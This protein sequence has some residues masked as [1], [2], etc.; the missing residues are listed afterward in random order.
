MAARIYRTPG[1]RAHPRRGGA[2][3][4]EPLPKAVEQGGG[5]SVV[6]ERAR[7]A[8]GSLALVA[9]GG[10]VFALLWSS[11][12]SVAKILVA[13]APPFTISAL[14]FFVAAAIAAAIARAL[15]QPF[16]RGAD[17]W[18]RILLLG[19]CQN[20]LYLG[21]FFAAMTRIPAALAAIIASAMPLV[22]AALAP[23]VVGERVSRREAAGLVAG[24]AGVAWIMGERLAGGVDLFGVGLA[25]AGVLA[26]SVATL[27][28]KRGAFGSGL[29]MV[30]ACQMLVGGLGCVPL[31]LL[32][33]DVTAINLDGE[34]VAAF[35]YQVLMPGIVATLIWF[36]LVGRLTAAGAS[37]FHFLNPIFGVA[38]A[39]LLL[40]EALTPADAVG[41]VL[42]AAG[43]LIVNTARPA[44]TATPR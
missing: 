12:F 25:V 20:T 17:A 2:A 44:R 3:A 23:A 38:F 6:S 7:P 40:G 30:V 42:V 28:V 21:L 37:A 10:I 1:R 26:L 32:F 5:M 9:V 41:V 43:I 36:W 29:L 13:H 31:A 11:A 14:R 19:I 24:F 15:G 16:P 27:T 8:A 35:A 4:A 22:V 33:E 34:M 39:F 18:R